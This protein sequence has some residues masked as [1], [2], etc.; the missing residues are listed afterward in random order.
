MPNHAYA[1]PTS[2]RRKPQGWIGI[3]AE[4]SRFL[5]L[6]CKSA[7]ECTTAASPTP[8]MRK[9]S[10][11]AR[12]NAFRVWRGRGARTHD[13]RRSI[14]KTDTGSCVPRSRCGPQIGSRRFVPSGMRFGALV[15]LQKTFHPQRPLPVQ[16]ETQ[17][18]S[19]QHGSGVGA[20]EAAARFL[21]RVLYRVSVPPMTRCGRHRTMDW[22]RFCRCSFP[23]A[24]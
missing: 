6:C 11:L 23:C 4:V 10:D 1:A 2:E 13:S 5:S 9:G 20:N 24:Q 8:A 17:N 15:C 18:V 14:S 19:G 21:Q 16:G 3:R 12:S 7:S 22:R